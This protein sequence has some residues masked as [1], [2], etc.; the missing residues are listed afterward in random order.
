M[1]RKLPMSHACV[2]CTAD[3]DR[4]VIPLKEFDLSKYHPMQ[5]LVRYCHM[6]ESVLAPMAFCLLSKSALFRLR[7][8]PF[9]FHIK[10]RDLCRTGNWI[11]MLLKVL[12]L[13]QS[14]VQFPFCMTYSKFL[15]VECLMYKK[16]TESSIVF[17]I[18]YRHCTSL[19]ELFRAV[20]LYS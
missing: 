11:G 14:V 7:T 2:I 19:L 20:W 9:A 12:F 17:P 1:H 16:Q 4:W 8:L 10:G 5:L 13:L 15:W 6:G 3:W 18:I